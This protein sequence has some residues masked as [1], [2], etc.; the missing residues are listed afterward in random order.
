MSEKC[1]ILLT[2]ASGTIGREVLRRLLEKTNYEV[3]VFDKKTIE[4]RL[5]YRQ[6]KQSIK[7]FFGDLT[8]KEDV[9]ELP[10]GFNVVI[11]LAALLQPKADRFPEL[12]QKVNVTG[13]NILINYLE[14]TSPNAF[15]LF[16]SCISVYGDRLLNPMIKVGD[17][18]IPRTNDPYAISKFEA[19]E[20]VQSTSLKWSIFRMTAILKRHKISRLMFHIPL[21]TKIETCSPGNAAQ[22]FINAINHSLVLS[23][24]I[25]NL[26]GGE[27]C[28][29]TYRE[30]LNK[31]FH[32]AGLGVPSFPP[33]AFATQNYHCGFYED[34]DVLN[35]I[36][37]FRSD[38]I[39]ACMEEIQSRFP[40]AK[41]IV[42]GTLRHTVKA[43]LLRQSSPY[44]A[45]ITANRRL[46]D[47]YFGEV[48]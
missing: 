40:P 22:A 27:R 5:F 31:V 46:V 39:S 45:Y 8:K 38:D 47:Y 43:N 15:F 28:R 25:F 35:D 48:L 24:K 13:T 3:T 29:I 6:Y 33:R 32:M 17:P 11:H 30:F 16:S 18:A 42:L 14:S 34:S 37:H 20:V 41:R 19:E 4:T 9:Q 23:G 21:D 7:L 44:R 36:L 2:G 1:K 12:V 26:G 10:S